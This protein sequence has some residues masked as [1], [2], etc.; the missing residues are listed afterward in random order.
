[1]E[2]LNKERENVEIQTGPVYMKDERGGKNHSKFRKMKLL[3]T[4]IFAISILHPA[5]LQMMDVEDLTE[6]QGYIPIK[7]KDET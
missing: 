7:E 5:Q 4:I 2:K 1:M 3:P 6:N